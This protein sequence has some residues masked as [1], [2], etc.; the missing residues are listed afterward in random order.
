[1]LICFVSFIQ[2]L[3]DYKNRKTFI[4]VIIIFASD[5]LTQSPNVNEFAFNKHHCN[6]E[7]KN[8]DFTEFVVLTM[9]VLIE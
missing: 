4:F 1:M 6:S 8:F 5:Q 3:D 9:E 7:N 2:I